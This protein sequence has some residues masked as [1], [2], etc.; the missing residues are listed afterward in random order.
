MQKNQIII[1]GTTNMRNGLWNTPLD[2]NQPTIP[3]SNTIL[4]QSL[5]CISLNSNATKYDLRDF[6]NTTTSSTLTS[7]FPLA[8][9]RRHFTT[10]TG[11]TNSLIIKH[12][13]KDTKTSKKY[14]LMQVKD[15]YSTKTLQ[16]TLIPPLETSLDAYPSQEP[17]NNPT[18][19]PFYAIFDKKEFSI[20][21]SE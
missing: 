6:L 11:L 21:Y 13:Q 12:F 15:L 2:T 9:K 14:I 16:L 5:D 17:S 3:Y 20:S 7:P 4:Y 19:E 18:N 10:W 1:E 8:I